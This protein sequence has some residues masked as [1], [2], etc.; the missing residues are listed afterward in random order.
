MNTFYTSER[1]AQM[2]I[3]LMKMHGIRKVVVSP[4][5]TNMCLVAS[6]QQDDFFELYSSVDERSAAYMACGLAAE[7]GE[8]VALSCTGATASRNYIP[9]LTEAYYR[10]L[11]ILAV[12][13]TQ[14]TGRIGQNIPQVIDRTS[15]LNDIVRM[16]AQVPTIHDAE[17]EWAYGVLLNKALLELRHHGGGPVHIN[18]TTTYSRDFSIKILPQAPK[19][20]RICYGENFP[21][22]KSGRTGIFVGAHEKWSPELTKA[23]DEFCEAY[24]AVVICDH[25]SN[26][27]GKYRIL[28][29]LIA[30]QKL[31]NASCLSIDVMIHIGDISGAYLSVNPA[32]VWRVNP[33]GEVRD[34]FR[35]LKY[36]FEMDEL[37]F[38]MRYAEWGKEHKTETIFYNEWKQERERI[39]SKIPELP[40][41]NIWIAKQT[42]SLLPAGSVLHLGI[43]NSLRSW[44]F[45]EIPESVLVYSNTGGFGIDGGVST[46]IG[47]SLSDSKKF[48]FGVVGDLAFFYDMNVVG[49]RHVGNNVRLMLI[50]NGRGT[51]F[52]NYTHPAARFG[53]DADAYMAAA[54]H[55]GCQSPHLVKHYAEDLG[56]EY[57]SASNKEEYLQAVERFT[58]PE[59][60]DRP[61]LFEI[62][63]DSKEESDALKM[64]N[65]LETSAQGIAK[66]KVKKILGDNGV[67]ILK[68]IVKGRQ[69][70]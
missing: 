53:E 44:N 41:S 16:S 32:Q 13:A 35:K 39:A 22:L 1:N 20:D 3:S 5:T 21:V 29:N 45:F 23:V 63:T 8:P 28:A 57:L 38:F 9:G 52:R 70:N 69:E 31:H 56:F 59:L 15:P 36:V 10:K 11:P 25:T 37:H 40:F 64:M 26:Y 24:N 19:I 27:H 49:N 43:L 66:Q 62:F 17:D 42:A 67:R 58:V 60:T 14:H 54:G 65:T 48:F 12:T 51:E 33:D 50:N 2:L 61:M 18:L 6:L 30:D 4:G 34:T 68:E 47:A 7:S 46:L 55:F